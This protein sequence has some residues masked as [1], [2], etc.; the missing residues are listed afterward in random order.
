MAAPAGPSHKAAGVRCGRWVQPHPGYA[1][2]ATAL[3][4]ALPSSS[5]AGPQVRLLLVATE[6]QLRRTGRACALLEHRHAE[7]DRTCV[8]AT[9][10]AFDEPTRALLHRHGYQDLG[11]H[12]LPDGMSCWTTYRPAGRSAPARQEHQ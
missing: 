11:R 10:Y 9:A 6:P 8:A 4:D 3:A 12:L 5:I 7:L 1:D 2:R